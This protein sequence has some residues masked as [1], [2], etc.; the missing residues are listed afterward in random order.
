MKKLIGLLLAVTMIVGCSPSATVATETTT[1]VM[2]QA[3]DENGQGYRNTVENKHYNKYVE[4]H[5]IKRDVHTIS[6]QYKGVFDKYVQYLAPNG[7]PINILAQDKVSDEQLLKAYNILAFY[8]TKHKQYDMTNVANKM[9]DKG[10]V[11]MMPNGADGDVELKESVFSGQPL[12]QMEVPVTG[13]AWYINN[14]YEHRDASYE[15]ILH[16]VHDYGIGTSSQAGALPELQQTIEKAMKNALPTK[17]SNWGKIGLW[18]LESKDWLME[19]S[20]EGSLEQEYI[21]SVVDSYYGLWEAF[22]E[23]DGGMW[24]LYVAKNREAI[25]TKDPVGY[26]ALESFLPSSFT[27]MDRVAPTFDGTFSLTYTAALSYTHKS[28][29]IDNVRLTGMLNSGILGNERDNILV[30]N[31]GNNELDGGAGIDIVQF[32]GSSHEYE[33]ANGIVKD[34]K[35]R[36]GID[37][38]K[39]IEVLRFTDKDIQ[40][41]Q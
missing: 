13:D 19:L 16:M 32:T 1:E 2:S 34:T 23:N 5:D 36:D 26:A 14:N 12:Y 29:Y 38:L 40:I 35:G 21:V 7:K 24:G 3:G 9:A 27:Y 11:L 8:L 28:Q 37:T 25:K 41:G 39:N 6:K 22:E 18:G 30:G 15:E 20:Q 31:A 4:L 33:I 10:A 17:K